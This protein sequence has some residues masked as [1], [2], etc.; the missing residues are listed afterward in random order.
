MKRFLLSASLLAF[1]ATLFAQPKT[2]ASPPET[3]TGT[4]AGHTL[5]IKYSSPRVNGREGKIF[6]PGGLIQQTHQE[7]PVWRAGAN[8][9]TALHTDGELKIGDLTV[10]AG[11]YTL[12]VNIA[13]NN[14]WVLI[15]SKA[16]GEWGLRYNP[17]DD[18]GK[19]PMTMSKPPSMVES[20]AWKITS[21]KKGTITLEWE[22]HS[23]SV[24]VTA[25]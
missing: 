10:P 19:T 18:L 25:R 12:F 9:A 2:P 11:D 24:P 6:G 1:T 13:D 15:V 4:I 23:A 21:G 14:R 3:A 7:Y 22:N 8:A 17:S 16:T 20:L 5:T